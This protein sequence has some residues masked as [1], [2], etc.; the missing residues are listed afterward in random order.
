[1]VRFVDRDMFMRYTGFGVGHPVMLR[2]F[3]RDCYGS[4]LMAP[5]NAMDVVDVDEHEEVINGD[6]NDTY[7]AECEEGDEESSD[8]ELDDESTAEGDGEDNLDEDEFDDL[9]SF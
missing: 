7:D 1:M 6:D 8:E 3:V 4:D 9:L 2:K 5:T